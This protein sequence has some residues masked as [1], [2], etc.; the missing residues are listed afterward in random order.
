M[1][2][3]KVLRAP[4][5]PTVEASYLLLAKQAMQAQAHAVTRTAER[6][7]AQFDHAVSRVLECKGRVVITGMGKSGL[8]GR[9]MVA[10]FAST[11]TPSFFLHP[12]D[13]FHGDLGMVTPDDL[14]IAI[15]Y[16][17]ETEEVVKLLP[18]IKRFGNPIIAIAGRQ[19]CSLVRH[20]D[21]WLDVGVEREICPN[22]LAPTTSTLVTMAMGDALAVALMEARRF[23]PH[24]FAQFHPGGS[25]GRR[26]LTRVEDVMHRTALPV[27]GQETGFREVIQSISR[28]RM[29]LT[30][31]VE[32]NRVIGLI[33]DGDLRRAMELHADPMQLCAID[34]M[35]RSPLTV[36][37]SDMVADAEERMRT[38]KVTAMVV[39]DEHEGLAGVLSIHDH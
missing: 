26:L 7:G 3:I 14:V 22:N 4:A 37:A 27:C 13:A 5:A 2:T 16:S 34:F 18:S 23:L 6:L 11:G 35:T 31:V 20:A 10:T 12:G 36:G 24:D 29:G 25:L 8:V 17:G 32:E 28:G 19:N 1:D 9:K 30:V 33:T 15:S 39:L 38:T 21:V